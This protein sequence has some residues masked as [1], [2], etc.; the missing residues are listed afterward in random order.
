MEEIREHAEELEDLVDDAE[1]PVA[2]YRELLF[3][4]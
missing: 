3:L 2:K 1:W 4:K